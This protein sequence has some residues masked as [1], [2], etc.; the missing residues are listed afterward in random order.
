[1]NK[2]YSR[3]NDGKGWKDHP[4]EESPLNAYNLNKGDIALDE[5]DN[6]VISLDTTKFDKSEAQGLIKNI[7]FDLQTGILTK[8]YYNGSTEEINTGISKL[9]MNLRFDKESQILYIVNADGTEDP[10]DLSVFITNY[11]FRDSDTIAHN[12]SSDGT[13]TSIV[14]EGSIGEKHLRP[15]YLADIKVEVAKAEASKNAAATSE[16][17]AKKSADAAKSSQTAAKASET[18]AAESAVNAEAS[19]TTA[20]QKATAAAN[21]AAAAKASQ[22]AAKA[23]ETNAKTSETNAEGYK[24]AAAS[25]AT[26]AAGSAATATTKAG[27]SSDYADMSK[28][29][30]VGTGGEVRE[31]DDTDCAEYYYEQTK[32]I[33]QGISGVIPMGTISYE[34]LANTDN[35]NAGY[36]FNISDSFTSDDRFTDGGGIFYGAGNNVLYTADGKWDVLAAVMVSGVKGSAETEY[37]QGFI[38]ITKVNIGLGNV[39][40][41]KAVSTKANQGL[42]SAEKTNA[43][44]NISAIATD[45]DSKDNTVTFISGDTADTT[46]LTDVDLIVSGEKHSALWNK[47]SLWAKNIRYL[48]SLIGNTELSIGNGTITG[49]ISEIN[50]KMF[51]AAYAMPVSGYEIHPDSYIH[52]SNFGQVDLYAKVTCVTVQDT[53][54]TIAMLP[55]GYRPNIFRRMEAHIVNND[56]TF[57]PIECYI[58]SNSNINVFNKRE[59]GQYHIEVFGSYIAVKE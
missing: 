2:A 42:S 47:V 11:E 6:R 40:N 39:G 37:R 26:S 52:R 23:S 50:S 59:T 34:G 44:K 8:Y 25:S 54:H 29:Y 38:N 13:V 22:T 1:M 53:W 4:S 48:I 10:I 32:R 45:G 27:E 35:Q 58:Y 19:A 5:I 28:S 20:T 49:A 9:N 14:K 41:F 36:L 46:G 17:N 21:S 55:S 12:V 18:N 56:G 43:R 30:A 51:T 57:T 3:V 24:T 31:N 15:D 16:A 7:T 33:S